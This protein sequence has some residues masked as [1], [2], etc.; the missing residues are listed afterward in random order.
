MP[1]LT[2]DEDDLHNVVPFNVPRLVKDACQAGSFDAAHRA[3]LER[4][5]DVAHKHYQIACD[6]YS[7]AELDG[8]HS[9]GFK[10]Q[11]LTWRAAYRHAVEELARLD[12]D[13][14]SDTEGA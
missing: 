12:A 5:R 3:A 2:Y 6:D 4:R 8:H 13:R 10:R 7:D 9:A 1:T 11:L 14:P